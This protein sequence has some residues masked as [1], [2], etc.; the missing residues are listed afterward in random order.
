MNNS[1]FKKLEVW[2]K[3]QKVTNEYSGS[4]AG[5]FKSELHNQLVDLIRDITKKG[6]ETPRPHSNNTFFTT[7]NCSLSLLGFIHHNCPEA[8]CPP[9]K[10]DTSGYWTI[11]KLKDKLKNEV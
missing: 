6:L 3:N 1:L 9:Q 10:F 11:V 8:L 2:H 7:Q 5:G 4:Y